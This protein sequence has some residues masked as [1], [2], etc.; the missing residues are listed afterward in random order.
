[1][2]AAPEPHRTR[3]AAPDLNKTRLFL[4]S[5]DLDHVVFDWVLMKSEALNELRHEKMC[6]KI[7]VVV[8]TKEE[9]VVGSCQSFFW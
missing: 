7:F 1:M 8:T 9:L 5:Q 6:L 3:H 2:G 4:H